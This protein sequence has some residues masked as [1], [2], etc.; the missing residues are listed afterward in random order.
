[1]PSACVRG[2]RL[3]RVALVLLAA[4]LCVCGPLL[5][6]AMNLDRFAVIVISRSS[7]DALAAA[8]DLSYLP[9]RQAAKRKQLDERRGGQLQPQMFGYSLDVQD[10]LLPYESSASAG[11]RTRIRYRVYT[12]VQ[13]SP[14]S[15][16]C[17]LQPLSNYALCESCVSVG[18]LAVSRSSGCAQTAGGRAELRVRDAARAGAGLRPPVQVR[19]RRRPGV[20]AVEG[21]LHVLTACLRVRAPYVPHL[22]IQILRYSFLQ[23]CLLLFL[24]LMV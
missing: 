23:H 10:Y 4:G 1:M 24:E 11:N 17:R 19:H 15:T 5:A 13:Y 16:L 3:A 8:G 9:S 7:E 22:S 14:S 18:A 12:S 2:V 21:R 20:H 6:S